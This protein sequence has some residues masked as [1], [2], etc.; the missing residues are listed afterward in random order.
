M[1]AIIKELT[2]EKEEGEL[3]LG[4]AHHQTARLAEG[5]EQL[6]EDWMG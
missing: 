1:E 3:C 2:R 6:E 5:T 4:I